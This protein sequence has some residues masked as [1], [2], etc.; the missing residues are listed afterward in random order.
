MVGIRFGQRTGQVD[1]QGAELRIAL[2]EADRVHAVRA[3]EIEQAAVFPGDGNVGEQVGAEIAGKGVHV[4]GE[5]LAELR[6]VFHGLPQGT[7]R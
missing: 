5:G 1:D 7:F 4:G 6:L 2:T 3:A